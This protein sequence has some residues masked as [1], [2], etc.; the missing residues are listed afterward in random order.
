MA[1][2]RSEIECEDPPLPLAH[3]GD[4]KVKRFHFSEIIGGLPYMRATVTLL[5][6]SKVPA[7]RRERMGRFLF[8]I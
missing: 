5:D 7:K 4:K 3:V 2:T 6:D 8:M 1:R